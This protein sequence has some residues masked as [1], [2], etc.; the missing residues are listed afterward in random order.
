MNQNPD[1]SDQNELVSPPSWWKRNW[2]WALPTG[3]CLTILVIAIV[4]VV[5]GLYSFAEGIKSDVGYDPVVE[6]VSKNQDVIEIIGEP[7]TSKGLES[8]NIK[9]NNGVRT[10]NITISIEG[11]NGDGVIHL[12][13]LGKDKDLTYQKIEVSIEGSDQIIE[14]DPALI[15]QK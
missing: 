9:I 4:V 7:I 6:A 2:K 13:T 15:D 8:F 5:S 14:I 11:P 12:M 10:N 3:G 1:Y